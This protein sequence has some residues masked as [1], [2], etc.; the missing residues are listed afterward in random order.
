MLGSP[1]KLTFT[2]VQLNYTDNPH[3]KPLYVITMFGFFFQLRIQVNILGVF[4]D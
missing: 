2:K 1:I 3:F 4:L